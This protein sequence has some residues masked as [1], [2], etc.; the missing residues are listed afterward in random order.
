MIIGIDPGRAYTK[1]CYL[2][3]KGKVHRLVFPS[4]VGRTVNGPGIGSFLVDPEKNGRVRIRH[5]DRLGYDHVVDRAVGQAAILNSIAPH[6]DYMRTRDPNDVIALVGECLLRFNPKEPVHLVTGAPVSYYRDV[7]TTRKIIATWESLQDI[8]DA[9]HPGRIR[10]AAQ[11]IGHVAERAKEGAEVFTVGTVTR[12]REDD[13]FVYLELDKEIEIRLRSPNQM[14]APEGRELIVRGQ[15]QRDGPLLNLL[16]G[17]WQ[18]NGVKYQVDN[19]AIVPEGAGALFALALDMETRRFKDAS[20]LSQAVGIIDVGV[21]TTDMVLLDKQQYREAASWSIP[22]GMGYVLRVVQDYV[23]TRLGLD[24]PLHQLYDHVR[25]GQVVLGRTFDLSPVIKEACA[26]LYETLSAQI[27]AR[28]ENVVLNQIVLVGGGMYYLADQF[29][30][31][32][33]Q[34]KKF[35]APEWANCLG[36]LTFGRW[37]YG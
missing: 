14:A 24:L 26:G 5:V 1:A 34:A 33:P 20:L 28:W 4:V 27:Q 7:A 11:S 13:R 17:E 31:T 25:E 9:A 30:N 18:V 6:V 36:Y 12:L 32:W 35:Q 2:T 29:K 23:K 19:V 8:E 37:H 15:L 16:K 22:T 21:Y 10:E 3:D